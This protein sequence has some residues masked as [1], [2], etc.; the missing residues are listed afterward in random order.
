VSA[1]PAC[2][3]GFRS[4]AICPR[5]GADLAPLMALAARAWRLR[6]RARQALAIPDFAR[7]RQ[8]AAQAQQVHA[9]QPGAALLAVAAWGAADADSPGAG[10]E[11]SLPDY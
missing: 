10:V 1:C 3:A 8:L 4:V 9:T 2:R 5:C 6:Q 11:E 7:A